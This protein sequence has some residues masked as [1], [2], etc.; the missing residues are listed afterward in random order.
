MHQLY[1]FACTQLKDNNI[2]LS[3]FTDYKDHIWFMIQCVLGNCCTSPFSSCSNTSHSQN[4]NR[5]IFQMHECTLT[6]VFVHIHNLLYYLCFF[7]SKHYICFYV[8]CTV[9]IYI[10]VLKKYSKWADCHFAWM[11]RIIYLFILLIETYR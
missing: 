3:N 10:Y 1:F 9:Y 2:H 5:K 7:C 6:F 11:L 8:Y 4:A